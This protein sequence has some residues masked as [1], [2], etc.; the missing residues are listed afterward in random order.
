VIEESTK[1]I[2]GQEVEPALKER[3]KHHNFIH[4]GCWNVFPGGRTLL[5]HGVVWEEV[6]HNKF[7]NHAFICDGRLKQVR[8]RGSH[9]RGGVLLR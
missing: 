1:K 2:T 6:V 3:G 7:V 4:V 8:M 9:G 5:Q